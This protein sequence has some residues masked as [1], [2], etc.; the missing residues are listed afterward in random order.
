MKQRHISAHLPGRSQP[1]QFFGEPILVVSIGSGVVVNRLDESG[2]YEGTIKS[3][4]P[5]GGNTGVATEAGD[6]VV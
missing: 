3:I 4:N 1:D 2:E 5:G 6:L